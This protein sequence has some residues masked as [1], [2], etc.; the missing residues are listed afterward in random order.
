MIFSMNCFAIRGNRGYDA[1]IVAILYSRLR[2]CYRIRGKKC[3]LLQNS[4]H[5]VTKINQKQFFKR[6]F[7][8]K[9]TWVKFPYYLCNVFITKHS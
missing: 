5:F 1:G 4:G 7:T 9:L 6:L 8:K 3:V 2:F